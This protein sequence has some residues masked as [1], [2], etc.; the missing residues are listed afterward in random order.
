MFILSYFTLLK[1]PENLHKLVK[2]T[3]RYHG[4]LL[5]PQWIRLSNGRTMKLRKNPFALRLFSYQKDL[6]QQQYSELLLFT[7][8]RN[9]KQD[10][11]INN[12]PKQLS[13]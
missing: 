5:L 4:D 9:E 11:W 3:D 1:H 2:L 7:S 12:T 6:L 8:W 13:T 10:F